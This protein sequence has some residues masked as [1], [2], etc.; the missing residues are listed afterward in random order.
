VPWLDGVML[1]PYL[2]LYG[3]YYFT[4]DNAAAILAAGGV[5]L[6]STPLLQGWSARATGGFDAKLS[7]GA[8]LAVGG[9]YGGIGSSTQIWTVTAKAQIPFSA[10]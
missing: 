3:D 1:A 8:V 4:E 10:R 7:S 2:G 5:P 9:Q 6:A